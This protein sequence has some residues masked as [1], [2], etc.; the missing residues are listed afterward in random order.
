MRPAVPVAAPDAAPITLPSMT[1]AELAA[2]MGRFEGALKG[3]RSAGRF[4]LPSHRS[5]LP[6]ERLDGLYTVGVARRILAAYAAHAFKIDKSKLGTSIRNGEWQMIR[7]PSHPLGAGFIDDG[8]TAVTY[9][10]KRGLI[11]GGGSS[12]RLDECDTRFGGLKE[13][14]RR[15][16]EDPERCGAFRTRL[17]GIQR[18]HA[19]LPAEGWF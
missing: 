18:Q 10:R 7:N 14:T 8:D 17:V 19:G 16:Y 5:R 9:G 15:F 12:W 13:I 1:T 6:S 2:A 3:R 4:P 11:T